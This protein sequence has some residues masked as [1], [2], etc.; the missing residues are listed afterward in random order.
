[1][2]DDVVE[3]QAGT[4]VAL[5]HTGMTFESLGAQ[6]R[7][8]E[9]TMADIRVGAMAVDAWGVGLADT[10]VVEHRRLFHKLA[11]EVKA[12]VKSDYL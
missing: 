6:H 3:R 8:S 12:W 5:T 7:G 4:G 1:M 11:V 2:A 9:N 10:D